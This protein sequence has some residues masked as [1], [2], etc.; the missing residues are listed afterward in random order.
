MQRKPP[1]C[2]G[3]IKCPADDLVK[4]LTHEFG[5]RHHPRLPFC[6]RLSLLR[7]T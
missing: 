2:V 4:T 1:A 6:P 5:A 3:V 7:S